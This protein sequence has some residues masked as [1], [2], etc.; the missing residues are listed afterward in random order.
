MTLGNR[1]SQRADV[2]SGPP[3]A[4]KNSNAA[5]RK[6]ERLTSGRVYLTSSPG[7]CIGPGTTNLRW[8]TSDPVIVRP[9]CNRRALARARS[10]ERASDHI[11]DR[12]GN[13]QPGSL[14]NFRGPGF[15]R[16]GIPENSQESAGGRV[17]VHDQKSNRDRLEQRDPGYPILVLSR[18]PTAT[19]SLG[20]IIIQ[21]FYP[22]LRVFVATLF[23]IAH[24]RLTADR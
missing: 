20:A 2:T 12:P 4:I 22:S 21:R 15:R 5:K 8:R 7:P 11:A 16:S 1:T 23:A 6:T 3:L 14:E 9:A 13:R 24:R 17:T 19:P 18:R 10:M